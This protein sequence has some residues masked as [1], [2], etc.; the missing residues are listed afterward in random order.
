MPF[1]EQGIAIE[2]Y[3]KKS[4]KI[5]TLDNTVAKI[6]SKCTPSIPEINITAVS[7]L[8]VK[9]GSSIVSTVDRKYKG[10]FQLI[11]YFSQN[12]VGEQS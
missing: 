4:V 8:L 6:I 10:N 2:K 1:F 7:L 11:I 3:A 5:I 9:I 12:Q